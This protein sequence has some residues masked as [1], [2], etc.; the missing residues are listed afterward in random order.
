MPNV[1]VYCASSPE[2][3]PRF[4]DDALALG[5]LMARNGITLVN[6]GG[7]MGLMGA[8]IDGVLRSGGR[9]I[10]VIPRFMYDKN[11]QHP[12]VTELIVTS[13]MHT[14]KERMAALADAA[15]AL[16][17][18]IGTFEELMEIITW[19]KLSLFHGNVVILNTLGYYDPLI[20]MLH[21]AIGDKF[22]SPR[23]AD[24]WTVASTPEEALAAALPD[25]H[26]K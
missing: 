7:R 17:G 25:I 3:D 8:T 2:I 20:E 14:R 21:K 23:C 6:G 9:A 15:I 4:V 5:S 1:T 19:R 24:Y 10:G 12:G 18:G 26:L 16:P 11:L 22:M 13:S